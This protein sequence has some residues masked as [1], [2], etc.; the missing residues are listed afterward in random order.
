MTITA[1]PA[2]SSGVIS[3]FQAVT[4]LCSPATWARAAAA[5]L[6]ATSARLARQYRVRSSADTCLPAS[7]WSRNARDR[8]SSRRW[9]ARVSGSYPYFSTAG[10]AATICSR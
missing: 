1:S 2:H 10:P 6:A 7:T 5:P 4:C 8:A 9:R 3:A